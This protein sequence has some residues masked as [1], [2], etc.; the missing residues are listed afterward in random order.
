MYYRIAERMISTVFNIACNSH[1]MRNHINNKW[2]DCKCLLL[3]SAW[4]VSSVSAPPL[5]RMH[6][7]Q[8]GEGGGGLENFFY[9]MRMN[10]L[11]TA[12]LFV[13]ES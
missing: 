11:W 12:N 3:A 13:F 7:T 8:Y 10:V 1:A 4:C 5:Y 9:S 6:L 2:I